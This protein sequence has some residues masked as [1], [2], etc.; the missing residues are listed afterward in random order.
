MKQLVLGAGIFILIELLLTMLFAVNEW[1]MMI[2][3]AGAII[4]LLLFILVR[5]T[6]LVKSNRDHLEDQRRQKIRELNPTIQF[7]MS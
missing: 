4:T 5:L 7:A 2:L 3:A 1:I 6:E